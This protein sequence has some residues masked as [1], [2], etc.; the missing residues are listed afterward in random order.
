MKTALLKRFKRAVN[1]MHRLRYHYLVLKEKIKGPSKE[2]LLR[3][4]GYPSLT[5]DRS[6]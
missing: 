2:L 5:K 1:M 3:F 6:S 4:Q